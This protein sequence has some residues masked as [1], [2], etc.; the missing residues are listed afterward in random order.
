MSDPKITACVSFMLCIR[1]RQMGRLNNSYLAHI[2]Y[3]LFG[4]SE[5]R[6]WRRERELTS[7]RLYT[8]TKELVETAWFEVLEPI[9]WGYITELR[10]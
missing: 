3:S 6:N 7:K 5:I 2:S 8:L 4:Q 10:I 1:R 9:R